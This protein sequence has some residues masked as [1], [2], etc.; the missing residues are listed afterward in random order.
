M[1]SLK[2][3]AVALIPLDTFWGVLSQ[4]L[5][6]GGFGLATYVYVS[7]VLKSPELSSLIGGIRKS[8]FKRFEPKETIA[9]ETPMTS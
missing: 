6:A 9:A 7:Y 3:V 2:P 5:L 1:Q 4:G 8:W